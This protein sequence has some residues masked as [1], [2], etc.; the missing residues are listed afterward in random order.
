M[1]F[2]KL[3]ECLAVEKNIGATVVVRALSFSFL[4]RSDVIGVIKSVSDLT[5]VNAKDG[6]QL[7]KRNIA[8]VDTTNHQVSL[9]IWED[10][11][12]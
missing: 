5:K 9:T 7:E 11:V 6:R 1:P 3:R 2:D 12:S 10:M 4:F 8:L